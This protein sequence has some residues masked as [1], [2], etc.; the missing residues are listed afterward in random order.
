VAIADKLP[1][2]AILVERE[3][4]N[5]AQNAALSLEVA[6]AAGLLDGRM[7]LASLAPAQ[8]SRRLFEELRYQAAQV[9]ITDGVVTGLSVGRSAVNLDDPAITEEML[10]EVRGL[11]TLHAANPPCTFLLPDF[12]AGGQYHDLTRL[13][14]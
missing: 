8:R 11:S 12:Q 9:G 5:G 2:N 13:I 1:T 7:T 10:R 3:A 4:K 14:E 6:A